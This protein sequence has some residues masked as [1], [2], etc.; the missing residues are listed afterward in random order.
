MNRPKS[1]VR[2][3]RGVA[4]RSMSAVFLWAS[5]GKYRI[6]SLGVFDYFLLVS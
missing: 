4:T 3:I 5:S 1:V 2:V 6:C